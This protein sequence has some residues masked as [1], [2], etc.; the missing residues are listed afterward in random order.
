[1]DSDSDSGTSSPGA[2]RGWRQSTRISDGVYACTAH[3]GKK[4]VVKA[5]PQDRDCWDATLASSGVATLFLPGKHNL[6]PAAV[7]PELVF[8]GK[9]PRQWPPHTRLGRSGLVACDADLTHEGVPIPNSRERLTAA[10]ESGIRRVITEPIATLVDEETGEDYVPAFI[11]VLP[12]HTRD[13]VVVSEQ[14]QQCRLLKS[15]SEDV[16]A[17]FLWLCKLAEILCDVGVHL[18]D[19]KADNIVYSRSAD[20]KIQPKLIDWDQLVYYG[21]GG[22]YYREAPRSCTS[23]FN[24]VVLMLER[25]PDRFHKLLECKAVRTVY[26]AGV[27]TLKLVPDPTGRGRPTRARAFLPLEALTAANIAMCDPF[28]PFPRLR[29]PRDHRYATMYG[30]NLPPDWGDID[31]DFTQAW[32]AVDPAFANAPLAL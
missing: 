3:S 23:F 2:S 7:V 22:N 14:L 11:R 25:T 19:L 1:M 24:Y 4:V 9:D 16:K 13:V 31:L 10:D 32:V 17:V 30:W 6:D 12:L 26:E 20:G 8:N 15:G 21:V 28:R 27:K 18:A 29:S 5:F